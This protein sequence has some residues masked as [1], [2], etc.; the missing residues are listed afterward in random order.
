MK[1]E[2]IKGLDASDIVNPFYQAHAG[3]AVARDADLFFVAFMNDKVVGAVRFCVENE[4]P[5]LRSMMIDKDY[6]RQKIGQQLLTA[7]N[8][9]LEQNKVQNTFC[10]PY[11]HLIEF[12]GSIGFQKI[13]ESEAPLFLQERLA[14]YRK[15][16]DQFTCMMRP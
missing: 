4:V 11:A 10:L 12:Y 15:K 13:A 2:M 16:P 6:R 7:F 5:M 3:K 9:Y 1:I 14:E 8:E